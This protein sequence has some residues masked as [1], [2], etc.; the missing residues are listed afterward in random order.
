MYCHQ[1]SSSNLKIFFIYFF[2]V[3]IVPYAKICQMSLCS[4]YKS[5][6][7]SVRNYII[8]NSLY[9]SW[10]INFV[11]RRNARVVPAV[12]SPFS[13]EISFAIAQKKLS[14]MLLPFSRKMSPRCSRILLPFR[15][16]SLIFI[17]LWNS[18][19]LTS[20]TCSF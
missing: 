17:F 7:P 15:T 10:E 12:R 19:P 3:E 2:V 20:F 1:N 13:A 9:S 14:F 6:S 11:R 18:K 16:V 5:I 8:F 4:A